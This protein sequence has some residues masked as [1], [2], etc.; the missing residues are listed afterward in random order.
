M[1]AV[2]DQDCPEA[3]CPRCPVAPTRRLFQDRPD[4]GLAALVDHLVVVEP[5]LILVPKEALRKHGAAQ[6][7]AVD[8]KIKP[9]FQDF[10][11]DVRPKAV[12]D[13]GE[14]GVGMA[15]RDFC[16]ATRICS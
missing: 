9:S 15:L 4:V 3:M 13:D 12:G 8:L 14:L 16:K 10:P 6:E 2:L 1:E 11:D 5:P 7:Q